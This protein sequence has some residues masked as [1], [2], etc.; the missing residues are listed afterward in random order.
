MTDNAPG[1]VFSVRTLFRAPRR[2]RY[3]AIVI[4]TVLTGIGGQGWIEA[5]KV[6]GHELGVD[7]AA[8]AIGARQH[9]DDFTGDWAA[10]SEV[11]DS[12]IVLVRPDHHV[13]WRSKVLPADPVADLRRVMTSVLGR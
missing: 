4:L 9:W 8:H 1:A 13:C 3:I 2:G 7:I 6:V 10:L 11:R 5:A 12:G